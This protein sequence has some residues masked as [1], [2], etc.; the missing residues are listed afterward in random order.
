MQPMRTPL[1]TEL[2]L[3]ASS[4]KTPRGRTADAARTAV[5]P[6]KAFRVVRLLMVFCVMFSSSK[7]GYSGGGSREDP[8]EPNYSSLSVGRGAWVLQPAIGA[9]ACSSVLAAKPG[10]PR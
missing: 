4:P 6:R 10:D 3:P 7:G 1:K 8:Q 5:P 2:G 9:A